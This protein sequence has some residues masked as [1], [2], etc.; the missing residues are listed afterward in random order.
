MAAAHRLPD[1][2][3]ELQETILG[4]L[5]DPD[6]L[7]RLYAV[8]KCFY[9]LVNAVLRRWLRGRPLGY[10]GH[11]SSSAA[12]FF[13]SRRCSGK[14]ARCSWFWRGCLMMLMLER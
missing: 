10:V 5:S 7:I 11:L 14:C 6:D 1:L 9:A 12:F 2:P 3:T 13:F 4:F 8:S